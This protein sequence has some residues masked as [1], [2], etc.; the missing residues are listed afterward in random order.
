MNESFAFCLD[1]SLAADSQL[2]L[3][4]SRLE[5][6]AIDIRIPSGDT[7][8]ITRLPAADHMLLLPSYSPPPLLLLPVSAAVAPLFGRKRQAIETRDALVTH[9]C[10]CVRACVSRMRAPPALECDAG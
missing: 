9:V 6:R 3:P 2:Q 10:L 8:A 7:L 4:P 5:A 1:S